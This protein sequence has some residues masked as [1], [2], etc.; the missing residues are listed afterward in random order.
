MGEPGS[1]I[2]SV[3]RR[4]KKMKLEDQLT[5][6]AFALPLLMMMGGVLSY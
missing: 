2:E 1:R 3:I 6:V 5:A 4:E